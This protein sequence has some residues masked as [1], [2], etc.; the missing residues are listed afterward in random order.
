[1]VVVAA[2]EGSGQREQRPLEEARAA[3][4]GTSERDLVVSSYRSP[5]PRA[6]V[7]LCMK[8]VLDIVAIL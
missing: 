6:V 7:Q 2:G 5:V 1:V 4:G 3:T 8:L